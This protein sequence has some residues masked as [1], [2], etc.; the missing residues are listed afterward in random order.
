MYN[1]S[2]SSMLITIKPTRIGIFKPRTLV[3]SVS[4]LCFVSCQLLESMVENLVFLLP[5]MPIMLYISCVSQ[6]SAKAPLNLF[7]SADTAYLELLEC[8]AHNRINP[9]CEGHITLIRTVR[10]SY[11]SRLS[12]IQRDLDF[13]MTTV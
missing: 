10:V 5:F 8:P 2:V 3:A 7:L 13:V 6:Y 9:V 12:G 1:L 4:F 11:S